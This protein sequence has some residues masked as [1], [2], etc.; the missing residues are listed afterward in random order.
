[1]IRFNNFPPTKEGDVELTESGR[2]SLWTYARNSGA[3]GAGEDKTYQ[4]LRGAVEAI[5]S[6]IVANSTETEF[7]RLAD[8]IDPLFFDFNK[9]LSAAAREVVV[10]HSR[11]TITRELQAERVLPSSPS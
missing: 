4:K 8:I 7:Y 3:R 6:T 2:E 11:R 10:D 1:M 9:D 5:S